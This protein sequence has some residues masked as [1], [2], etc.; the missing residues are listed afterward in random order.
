M[1]LR[2]T[3]L[4]MLVSLALGLGLGGVFWPRTDAPAPPSVTCRPSHPPQ[5]LAEAPEPVVLLWGNSLLFDHSWDSAGFVAVNCAR[6]G[7]TLADALLAS[8]ALPQMRLEAILLTFGSVE[9]IR[10]G[11]IDTN[12]WA[13]DMTTLVT[14]L[15][16]RYPQARIL[17]TTIPT[18]TRADTPWRYA[19]RPELVAMNTA[20]LDLL[21]ADTLDL[22]ALLDSAGVTRQHYDGVH[23]SRESYRFWT[24]EL[25]LRLAP[26]N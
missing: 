8:S 12:A 24:A 19:D 13:Q 20:L 6:Q 21:E 9:L 7:M 22:S 4:L 2:S 23:L 16:A 17:A 5:A 15:R 18:G 1:T 25:A 10:P 11:P 3:A 14:N 26:R